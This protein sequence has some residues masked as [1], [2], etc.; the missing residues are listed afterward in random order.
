MSPRSCGPRRRHA[1]SV[2]LAR[3]NTSS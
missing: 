2:S 1:G 3:S